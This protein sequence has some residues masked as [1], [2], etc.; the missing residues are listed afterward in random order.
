MNSNSMHR[1]LLA[2]G[3][4]IATLCG[5]HAADKPP[6]R[7]IVPASAGSGIDTI[8]RSRRPTSS[9]SDAPAGR[10]SLEV[11]RTGNATPPC[12]RPG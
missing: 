6:L 2:V 4:A 8:L 7:I 9:W 11:F 12:W 1:G 5:A 3:L 10:A